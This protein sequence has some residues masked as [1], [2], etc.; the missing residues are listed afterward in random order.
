MDLKTLRKSKIL[1]QTE[2]AKKIGLTKQAISKWCS[3]K[4]KPS[5]DTTFRLAKALNIDVSVVLA[6][7]YGEPK[8]IEI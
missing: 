6:C 8:E 4:N 7:F 3:G 2:L 5:L 1:T